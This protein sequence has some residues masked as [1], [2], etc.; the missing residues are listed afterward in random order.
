[1][2]F[3]DEKTLKID[4]IE[5]E[6]DRFVVDFA[7]ILEKHAKYVIVSGYVA[8]LLGRSR[9]TEDI[10]ILIKKMSSERFII[11]FSELMENGFCCLNA[12]FGAS[13]AKYLSDGIS[14]RFAKKGKIIPNVELKFIRTAFDEITLKN[15]IRALM[16]FGTIFISELEM[17]IAFKRRVLKSEKDIED[18]MHI[19]MVFNGRID[20]NKV[21]AYKKMLGG[22]YGRKI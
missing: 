12:D 20:K 19:E 22:C 4:R 1:M 10:D 16:P 17:Q 21:G 6:L 7:R 14:V 5:T 2:E 18:A 11:L 15:R 8:I 13:A 3:I 9:A